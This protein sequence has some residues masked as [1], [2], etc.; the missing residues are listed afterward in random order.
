MIKPI[1]KYSESVYRPSSACECLYRTVYHSFQVSHHRGHTNSV[2]QSMAH[3]QFWD[4]EDNPQ[5]WKVLAK[6]MNNSS[7]SAD[8]WLTSRLGFGRI[9]NNFTTP[10][11]NV[12][13]MLLGP[14]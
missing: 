11:T 7:Q 14:W 5:I 4:G 6:I 3:P 1:L 2:F 9:S 12:I 13:K 8:V 10:E